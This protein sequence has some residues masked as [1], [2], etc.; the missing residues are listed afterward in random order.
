MKQ[1]KCVKR[2]NI[3]SKN[4]EVAQVTVNSWDDPYNGLLIWSRKL[5]DLVQEIS[6]MRSL[7]CGC[8]IKNKTQWF[9][10]EL[11]EEESN[12]LIYTWKLS[13]FER[14]LSKIWPLG[15]KGG[16]SVSI[17]QYGFTNVINDRKCH[18]QQNYN[19]ILNTAKS[20]TVY[21]KNICSVSYEV[22]I[23]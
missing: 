3:N 4:L 16:F 8:I 14:K 2:I 15:M 11:F 7:K 23:Y 13:P 6:R 5:S 22:L 19:G 18:K 21:C 17:P 1:K 10:F 20:Y 12:L 9:Q